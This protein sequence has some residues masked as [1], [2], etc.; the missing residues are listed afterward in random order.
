MT[1]PATAPPKPSGRPRLLVP[2]LTVLLLLLLGIGGIVSFYV[3]WLWFG[4]VGFRGVFTTSLYA[5]IMLFVVGML[6][7]AAAVVGNAAIAYRLRPEY[8]P[9]SIEQQSLERYRVAIES[10]RRLIGVAAG[11]GL[12]LLVGAALASGWESYLLWRNPTDFGVDDPQFGRDVSY[13]VFTLPFLR[14]VMSLL[15]A[16]AVISIIVAAVVHYLYGGIKLQGA[17]EKITR[18]A[19]AH[20]SVLFGVFLLFKAAGYYLDRFTLMV[21]DRSIV[22][23]ASYTDINAVLPA[24]SILVGV[25]LLGALACFANVFLRIAALPILA[26]VLTFLV[27]L[28]IG[29][30]YPAVIEQFRVKP[31][32]N[33]L[34]APYIE[35]NIAGTRAAYGLDDVQY[36]SYEGRT[37][38]GATDL[39]SDSDASTIYNAR[40]MDPNVLSPT[41]TQLQQI[42]NVYGF[43]ESLDIDRYVIDGQLSEQVLALRELDTSQLVGNQL[44]WINRHLVFTHGNGVVAAPTNRVGPQGSPAFGTSD[45]PTTG[46]IEVDQGR[47]Y[48]G[49]LNTDYSVVGA[50]EDGAPREFDRPS[51]GSG[52]NGQVTYTY[53]G[54]GGIQLSN[55]IRRL[56]F[57][58]HFRERNL[59]LSS[60]ITAQSK[61]LMVRDPADRVQ[62]VA[63]FLKLDNDPYPTVIDGRILW[64]VDGYTSSAE[65]PYAERIDYRA[66]VTDSLLAPQVQQLPSDTVNYV[67]NSVKATVDAYDGTVTLYQFD[68]DDAVLSSWMKVFPGIVKPESEISDELRAHFRYPEDIFKIQREILTRYHVDDPQQ[69][70]NSQGFW[71][72]PP[73]PTT[74]TGEPQ[75]SYYVSAQAPGQEKPTFQL[76]ASLTQL[77]RDNLAAWMSVSSDP[78]DYGTLRVLELPGDTA[79]LGPRQVQI[80]FNTDPNISR[81]VTLLNQQNSRVIFG[82]LLTLPVAGGFIYVEPLYVEGTTDTSYP[83]LRKVLVEFGG[84]IAYENTLAEALD[85]L[86]GPGAGEIVAGLAQGGGDGT[87]P[88]TGTPETPDNGQAPDLEAAAQEIS[89]AIAGLEDAQRS[90]DFAAYGDAL[91]RLDEA[92][93]RYLELSG[94]EPAPQ[95]E[96]TESPSPSPQAEALSGPAVPRGP[97][98]P[99]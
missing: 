20:F 60:A 53:E 45:L 5:R 38:A 95:S 83:L 44:N 90:G 67:R 98:A 61:L 54:E 79:I 29:A 37:S 82:N 4:E 35:R 6:A 19:G 74:E 46:E 97:T 92:T 47:I 41:F 42:R 94:G 34:E 24:R 66:A 75:P 58:V 40:L 73:D 33:E 57:A 84:E 88:D 70:F 69:F 39:Q 12:G 18:G 22:T 3:D 8:R 89:D 71:R 10:R 81:D 91:A 63:P 25:A 21:S 7:T 76:T 9:L 43:Q 80:A 86:F 31:N 78:E 52:G 55:P 56:A 59:L 11:L 17:G 30:V 96:A 36:Q 16:L 23:G 2:V 77:S 13:Y 26:V 68:P 50:T 14:N 48:Y 65:Y 72:V 51:E 15:I 32:A 1:A 99:T 85:K 87:T 28:V 64:V 27:S 49:E 93:R 62:K